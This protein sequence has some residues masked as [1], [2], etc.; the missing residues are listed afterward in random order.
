MKRFRMEMSRTESENE[1]DD[2]T[3]NELLD[4]TNKPPD[5]SDVFEA[6]MAKSVAT[7][8]ITQQQ[9]NRMAENKRR[10][11]EK[12]KSRLLLNTSQP[13]LE[14]SSMECSIADTEPEVEGVALE[15]VEVEDILDVDMFLENLPSGM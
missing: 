4:N 7:P 2:T 14:P 5:N 13:S 11:E 12:R 10:A 8:A 15:P 9:Q 6:I 1:D 3:T